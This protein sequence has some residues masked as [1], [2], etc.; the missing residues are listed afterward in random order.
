MMCT[1]KVCSDMWSDIFTEMTCYRCG[2]K[3]EGT[4]V[5]KNEIQNE[6]QDSFP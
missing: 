1:A 6:T 5:D 4:R 3:L 2:T